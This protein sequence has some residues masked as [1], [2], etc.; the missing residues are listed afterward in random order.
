M[1]G[2]LGAAGELDKDTKVGAEQKLV[3]AVNACAPSPSEPARLTVT[4]AGHLVWT[5]TYAGSDSVDAPPSGCWPII[6]ERTGRW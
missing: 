3:N 6:V 5:R 1:L 2:D 4:G